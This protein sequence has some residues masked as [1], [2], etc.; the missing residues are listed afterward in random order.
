MVVIR[1][2]LALFLLQIA[3][4]GGV[5]AMQ[6]QPAEQTSDDKKEVKACWKQLQ[7]K[8]SFNLQLSFLETIASGPVK[9]A[10]LLRLVRDLNASNVL[11]REQVEKSQATIN[12]HNG[13]SGHGLI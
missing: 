3:L 8:P 5:S 6:D 12:G 9:E 4:L 10:L 2:I 11:L 13:I 7:Q 1:K